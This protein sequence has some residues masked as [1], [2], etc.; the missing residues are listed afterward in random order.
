[1]VYWSFMQQRQTGLFF[2]LPSP[3]FP[4]HRIS[5]SASATTTALAVIDQTTTAT[6][7]TTGVDSFCLHVTFVQGCVAN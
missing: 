1:M 4:N 7:A 2:F 3:E 5:P 6:E